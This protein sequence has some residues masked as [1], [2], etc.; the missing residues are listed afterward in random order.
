M[1]ATTTARRPEWDKLLLA[2]QQNNAPL[3]SQLLEEEGVSANHSNSMGQSALHVASWWGHIDCVSLL[4][5]HGANVHATNQLTQATPLHCACQS[6]RS[7]GKPE[8][9]QTIER[10]L[11]SGADPEATDQM[12]RKAIDYI[13]EEE[14]DPAILE[15]IQALLTLNTMMVYYYA[16]CPQ[17]EKALL[18]AIKDKSLDQVQSTLQA[19]TKGLSEEEQQQQ[20]QG[21]LE[22]SRKQQSP[23]EV[24]IESWSEATETDFFSLQ[25]LQ[26]F[27]NTQYASTSTIYLEV[28][29]ENDGGRRTEVCIDLLCNSILQRYKGCHQNMEDDLLQEWIAAVALFPSSSSSTT[30]ATSSLLWLD[31]CRRNYIDLAHV[32]W[33]TFHIDPSVVKG[34]QGMTPLHFAARSG[35]YEMVEYLLDIAPDKN[36]FV[37]VTNDLGQTALQAATVNQHANVAE[38]LQKVAAM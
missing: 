37:K 7:I 23:L 29:S 14:N 6:N 16:C 12:G 5:D 2:C 28:E 21:T 20:Q 13:D 35:H 19:L 1:S 34:R 15:K 38:L 9:I 10:L 8:R 32:W 11:Q 31:I 4:L 17:E 22:I 36:E 27:L 25:A 18:S 24:L 26:L 33:E 30:A 3:V